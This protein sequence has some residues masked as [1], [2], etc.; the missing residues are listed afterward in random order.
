MWR[1]GGAGKPPVRL[2]WPPQ[3]P[4][5]SPAL[6]PRLSPVKATTSVDGAHDIVEMDR[7]R[8][9]CRPHGAECPNQSSCHV[10]VEAD[11]TN[12]VLWRNAKRRSPT[13]LVRS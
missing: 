11:V 10:F 2:R 1:G 9:D 6:S 3:I 5:V 4:S 13:R 12:L 7:M 8:N